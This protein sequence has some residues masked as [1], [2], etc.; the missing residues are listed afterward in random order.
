MA[1]ELSTSATDDE[2]DL[3]EL[4]FALWAGKLWVAFCTV[5]CTAL[6]VVY[7]LSVKPEFQAKSI[8]DLKSISG[9]PSLSGQLGGL[10]A[11]AGINVP[12]DSSGA[13]LDRLVGRD[14]VE[15]LAHDVNL[16]EDT[17]F[18]PSETPDTF[19]LLSAL[20]ALV[21]GGADGNATQPDPIDQI[22]KTYSNIVSVKSTSN[23]SYEVVV[24]HEDP[25]RAAVIA[26]AI[27]DRL[28]LETTLE[29]R[30]EDMARLNYLSEQLAQAATQ[31]EDTSQA[32]SGFAMANSLSATGAFAQLSEEI[33]Q[34][35]EQ[36][37]R[38]LEMIAAVRD[39]ISNLQASPAPDLGVYEAVK[40]LHPIVDDVEFRR[41]LGV[42]ESL[43]QW[44]WPRLGR[45]ES[46]LDVLIERLARTENS[47]LDLNREAERYAKSSEQLMILKRDAAIAEATYQVL[48]EQVKAES[49]VSGFE[50]E[51]I[52]IYQSA[53]P[54]ATASAPRKS[55][56]AALGLV[57]GGFLGAGLALVR[58]TMSGRFYTASAVGDALPT[59]LELRLPRLRKIK[60]RRRDDLVSGIKEMSGSVGFVDLSTAAQKAN[61]TAG[62]I[63]NLGEGELG[64]PVGLALA[65][66]VFDDLRCAVVLLNGNVPQ[67]L[68]KV[69]SMQ[70]LP[71]NTYAFTERVDVLSLP[72][73]DLHLAA[74]CVEKLLATSDYDKILFVASGEMGAAVARML[75]SEKVF[76]TVISQPG[77]TTRQQILRLRSAVQ[78][79]VNLSVAK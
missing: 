36:R 41:L 17:F 34:L 10:A 20:R 28:V 26:N 23:G 11:I 48:V 61:F 75:P 76:I 1:T 43:T 47:L 30:S 45:L 67:W 57:L 56:I 64:L 55:L 53:T 51:T 13:V 44:Q 68:E 42:S 19:N 52:R 74:R 24:T 18:I 63:V 22:F 38:S 6:A 46:F 27:V 16:R 66:G 37:R 49:L 35:N 59:S 58:S 79:D 71:L 39:I 40:L 77:A 62:L 65:E 29:K 2:I 5:T 50:G 54:P 9:G 78:V 7:A 60:L 31:M 72:E 73:G 33:Y 69:S 14:F 21:V 32:V 3:K 12:G 8:F 25:V 4:F 70:A 15:R